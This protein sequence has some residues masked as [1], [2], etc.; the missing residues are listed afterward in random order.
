[1]RDLP[2][3]FALVQADR[4]DAAVRRLH[5]GQALNRQSAAAAAAFAAALGRPVTAV[6]VPEE[7]WPAALASSGFSA[8]TIA[9]WQE[10]FRAFNTGAIDFERRGGEPA[11]GG[12]PLEDAIA[13]VVRGR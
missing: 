7:G 6:A 2:E 5:E 11:R 3:D 10:L 8:R 12:T 9:S 4:A 1:V 13:A